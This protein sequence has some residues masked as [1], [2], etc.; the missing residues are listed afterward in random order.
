MSQSVS[1][2]TL[3]ALM[4]VYFVCVFS[5]V[6]GFVGDTIGVDGRVILKWILKKWDREAWTGLLRGSGWGQV[7][8]TC[9]SGNEPSGSIKWGSFLD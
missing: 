9:K 3:L 7:A 6:H 8:G 2:A 4:C 5:M 1:Q